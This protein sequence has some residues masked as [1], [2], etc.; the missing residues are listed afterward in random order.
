MLLD[1]KILQRLLVRIRVRDYVRIVPRE[2]A[3][4]PL[5]MGLGLSRFSSPQQRFKLLYLAKDLK[6]AVAETIIRDRFEAKAKRELLLEEFDGYSAADI[7]TRRPLLLLDLRYEGASLL[8]ISTDAVRAK[9]QEQGRRF[10]QSLY[11]ET[12]LDG[13]AYMSRITNR[14]CL[15]VF[16]RA[17]NDGLKAN[18]PRA[19]DLPNLDDLTTVLKELHVTVIKNLDD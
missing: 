17:V 12:E 2:Y 15:A 6:T 8:G 11:D 5:G 4:T 19:A 16:D 14:E 13:I 3:G 1:Q 7:S 9:E 10:S 18:S